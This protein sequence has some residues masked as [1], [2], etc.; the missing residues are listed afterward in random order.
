MHE[1]SGHVPQYWRYVRESTVVTSPRP[2]PWPVAHALPALGPN[3]ALAMPLG[4]GP[5]APARPYGYAMPMALARRSVNGAAFQRRWVRSAGRP[6]T[7][8]VDPP[9][10]P[11]PPGAAGLLRPGA[12]PSGSTA[13]VEGPV[14]PAKGKPLRM[15]PHET[16]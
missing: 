13:T 4:S 9:Y 10:K 2:C 5:L 8:H 12:G 3:L 7:P 6:G 15:K 11:P 14:G 16:A 1:Y